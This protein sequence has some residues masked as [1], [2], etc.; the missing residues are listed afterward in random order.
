MGDIFWLLKFQIFFGVLEI[1]DI[2]WGW[3]VDAGPEPTYEEKMRVPPWARYLIL[4]GLQ[5]RGCN[6]KFVFI[7]S[8]PETYVVGTQ[9]NHSNET[10]LLCIQNTSLNWWVSK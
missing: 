7:I 6:W 2:F 8:Q 4:S 10:V 1:P 9:K 5:I 3:T